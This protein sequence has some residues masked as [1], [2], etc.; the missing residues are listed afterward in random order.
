MTQNHESQNLNGQ[1]MSWA[2][3]VVAMLWL[4][5]ALN[6]FDRLM[7]TTMR[8]SLKESIAMTDAQFG[9]L[10]SVFLWVYGG[11]SPLA[12][13]LADRFSR[14]RVIV[15][16]L[17]VWSLVTWLTGHAQTFEQMLF[18]RAVMGVSEA[19]YIP[20]ALA[21]IVDYHRGPTRSLATGIHM[22][23]VFAG[24]ALGGFGGWIA[25]GFGWRHAFDLFGVIGIGYALLLAF[26]LKDAADS[27]MG[28]KQPAG[29]QAS[30]GLFTT[31]GTLFSQGAFLLLLTYWSILSFAN[32]AIVGWLPSYM[33]EHFG[34]GE[35]AAG[36]SATAY[37]QTAALLGVLVGGGWA[38]RWSR[39]NPRG[40][41]LVPL[42]G[43]CVAA[44]PIFLAGNTT[45]L[46]V[47]VA[48]LSLYGF[49]RAFA[50]ANMMPILCQ[51]VDP[52]QRA[53]AYGI[54]NMSACLIGGVG[55]YV[56]GALKDAQVHLGHI[57][58]CAAISLFLGAG[59]LSLV[60][61][62]SSAEDRATD[63]LGVS[64]PQKAE[65]VT[66]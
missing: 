24:A 34:L 32:W 57:F 46:I 39:T 33:N 37:L 54:L 23:G 40:R 38:D 43:L 49:A 29:P 20:A 44:P 36:L 62:R 48:G 10:T 58:P 63:A 27:R 15:G 3:A 64:P 65:S 8:L 7:I 13:F 56:G 53:T 31:L 16:S 14:S 30:L 17:L 41:I 52:R 45:L 59:V 60:K 25:E 21:L 42:V 2:W 66:S 9:L 26:V 5:A 35:G 12:G 6:Y 22:S 11:L 50:D 51:V 4:V 19:C 28:Q 1:R 61:P 18:A 55:I 47:A